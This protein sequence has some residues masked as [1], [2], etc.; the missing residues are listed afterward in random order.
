[1]LDAGSRFVTYGVRLPILYEPVFPAS[2]AGGVAGLGGVGIVA[3]GFCV[4]SC[5]NMTMAKLEDSLC[6]NE[7]ATI[8]FM[9]FLFCFHQFS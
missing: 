9:Y 1:M 8:L 2:C 5:T 6:Q 4:R 3:W 7:K